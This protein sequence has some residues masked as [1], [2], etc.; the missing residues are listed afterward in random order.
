MTAINGNDMGDGTIG[1]SG[2]RWIDH[3]ILLSAAGADWR[4]YTLAA[5]ACHW[6]PWRD[7]AY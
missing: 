2:A 5:T 4:V 6:Y 7:A 3:T 1:A